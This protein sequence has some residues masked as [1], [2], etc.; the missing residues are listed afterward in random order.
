MPLLDA[1][2]LLPELNEPLQQ[3]AVA[4]AHLFWKGFAEEHALDQTKLAIV[5]TLAALGFVPDGADGCEFDTDRAAWLEKIYPADA[6]A[7]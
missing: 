4:E 2:E 6:S 5:S 7:D 1:G 3:I